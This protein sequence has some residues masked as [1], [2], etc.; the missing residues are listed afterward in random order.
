MFFINFE[1]VSVCLLGTLCSKDIFFKEKT[2]L[3][4]VPVNFEIKW[5]KENDLLGPK[6]FFFL[7]NAMEKIAATYLFYTKDNWQK[8]F[9]CKNNTYLPKRCSKEMKMTKKD[10]FMLVEQLY[11]GFE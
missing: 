2:I 6:H 9:F 10:H 3:L 8:P 5:P 4:N 7:I 1:H 11:T